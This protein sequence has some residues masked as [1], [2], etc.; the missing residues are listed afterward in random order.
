MVSD[1][2]VVQAETILNTAE[3]QLTDSILQR[4]KLQNALAVLTGKNAFLFKLAEQPL[5]IEPLEIP[6]GLP[7]ELLDRRPDIAAAERR[8]A[9]AN[10]GI[11]VATAAFYPAI[12]FE[13]LAGFQT[14]YKVGIDTL[15]DWPSRFWALGP[16]LNSTLV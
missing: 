16:T 13:G 14:G 15:F 2:D 4:A 12:R 5:A 9:A 1:L 3:A 8:M 7:S 10:A 11:G 6:T